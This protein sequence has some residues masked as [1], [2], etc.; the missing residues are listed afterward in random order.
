MEK[1]SAENLVLHRACLK[2][3]HCHT[4]LRLGGYAFDRDDP[5]GRFYCTQ[6]YR[7]PAKIQ[8][9][10]PKRSMHRVRASTANKT[11]T[12]AAANVKT[13]T[14]SPSAAKVNNNTKE[15]DASHRAREGIF[16]F[17]LEKKK[18]ENIFIMLL[19]SGQTP[20]RIEFEN[21]DAQSDGEPSRDHIIDENEWTDR[22]FGTGTE[23]SESD[24]TSTDDSDSAS[25]S[26]EYEEAMGSPLGAQ[27]LQLA[28]DWIGKQRYSSNNQYSDE[29]DDDDEFY[30]SSEGNVVVIALRHLFHNLIFI[31]RF[32]DE[33][34]ESQTEGEELEKA[35]EIRMQEVKLKPLPYLP[36]DT[37]TEVS[38]ARFVFSAKKKKILKMSK[39]K[40][41]IYIRSKMVIRLEIVYFF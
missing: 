10:I 8:R 7:L 35:R 19:P 17:I 20:E 9:P 2:C 32:T 22:N 34:A 29:D 3:H 23:D 11:E 24:I 31:Y 36:T 5:S 30:D 25:D 13:A 38:F 26:E 12:D 18:T 6:H 27:T 21:A 33:G 41:K 1:I 40:Y 28:N 4:S 16:N 15:T 14:V 39:V 37:E